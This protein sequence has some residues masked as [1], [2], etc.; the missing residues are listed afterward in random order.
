[1]AGGFGTRLGERTKLQ[2]KP[3]IDVD[4]KPLLEYVLQQLENSSIKKYISTFYLG[5][6]ILQY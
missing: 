2:P 5:E 6:Q 3:L 4:G 1:M